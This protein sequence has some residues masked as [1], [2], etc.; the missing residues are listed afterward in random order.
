M[1]SD[2][3]QIHTLP[4]NFRPDLYF[5]SVSRQDTGSPWVRGWDNAPNRVPVTVT[6]GQFTFHIQPSHKL[7]SHLYL[8]DGINEVKG[9][10]GGKTFEFTVCNPSENN[11]ED[12]LRICVNNHGKTYLSHQLT[13]I[14]D[15]QRM[16]YRYF[17]ADSK[18]DFS[19]GYEVSAFYRELNGK[20]WLPLTDYATAVGKHPAVT[21]RGLSVYT[22]GGIMVN[23]WD[24]APD[25]NEYAT[26]LNGLPRGVYIIQDSNGTRKFTRSR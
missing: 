20:R 6:N 19:A 17:I 14:Y 18:A 15:G 9:N 25:E 7:D 2:C 3:S 8:L 5:H 22:V 13:S 23:S 12:S 16:T 26:F 4:R 10:A 24:T 1:W 21:K 11:F